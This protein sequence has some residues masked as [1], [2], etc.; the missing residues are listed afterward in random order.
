V[1]VIVVPFP[2]VKQIGQDFGPAL[3]SKVLVLEVSNPI[4]P[5]DG[6]LGAW[7]RDKGA[8]LADAEL[9]PGSRVVRGFNAVNFR[10]L[11]DSAKGEGGGGHFGVPLAGDDPQALAVACVLARETGWEPVIVGGLAMGKYLIPGTPVTAEHT[12]A[13]IRQIVAGLK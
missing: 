8:G 10:K 5:R 13:E 6:D 4:V 12:P 9:L 7:A 1:A 3:A 11:Q 2:A